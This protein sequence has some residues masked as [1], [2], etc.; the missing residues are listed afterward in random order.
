MYSFFLLIISIVVSLVATPLVS[1]AAKRLGFYDMPKAG[2]K[3]HPVPVPY[4]GTAVW[5]SF[6]AVLVIF[7]LFTSF[8]TGTLYRMR[9]L[10]IG[11]TLIYAVGLVDDKYDL[12]FRIKFFWQGVAALVLVFYGI[13]IKIFPYYP[14]NVLLSVFWVVLVMNAI[15]IID[16]MDG[17]STGTSTIAALSFFLITLPTEQSYVNFSS[18]AL[19]GVLFSFWLFNK[20]RAKIFMGDAGSL[21]TG[22]ILASIA[23]GAD[24]S[25]RNVVGLCSPL[26]I[27]GIPVYDTLLVM[28]FRYR[29]GMPI[30]KGSKDHFALRLSCAGFSVWN[31]DLI[32]YFVSALLGI[33]AFLITILPNTYDFLLFCFVAVLGL[34]GSSYLD[35]IDP[36]KKDP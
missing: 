10:L 21:F 7:R 8:E 13:Y 20:P 23:M 5:L 11:G 25:S 4:A 26:L 24:Y 22:F 34:F 3:E 15:N 33:S 36:Y 14:L 19:A 2:I 28:F 1:Y 16:I 35:S 29:R 32:A 27:L 6:C 17:L 31:I 9:A 30:F 18:L 12:D